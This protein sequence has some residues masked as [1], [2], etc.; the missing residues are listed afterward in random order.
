MDWI[1]KVQ[2]GVQRPVLVIIVMKLRMQETMG[3]LLPIRGPA[4]CSCH[5]NCGACGVGSL[6][7]WDYQVESLSGNYPHFSVL[8]FPRW[9]GSSHVLQALPNDL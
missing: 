7:P 2:G 8:Y 3:Y 1:F 5:A 6:Y 4:Y 9:S